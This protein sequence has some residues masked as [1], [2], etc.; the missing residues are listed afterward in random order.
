M[1]STDM[2]SGT[3]FS[4]YLPVSI[5]GERSRLDRVKLKPSTESHSMISGNVTT[6]D[7][8]RPFTAASNKS[9]KAEIDAVSFTRLI[10]S[11]QLNDFL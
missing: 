1:D 5:V 7:S 3:I 4:R 10:L 9:S 6:I 2:E 8:S 11:T